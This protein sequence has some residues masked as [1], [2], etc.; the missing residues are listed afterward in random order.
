MISPQHR[1]LTHLL[2]CDE[3]EITKHTSRVYS[4]NGL[5]FE[6][7][8][9][10]TMLRGKTAPSHYTTHTWGGKEWSIRE[11]GEKSKIRK[12]ITNA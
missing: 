9:R 10:K 8:G 11:L 5:Y 6:I 2:N 7:L 3:S 4:W 1:L 12:E